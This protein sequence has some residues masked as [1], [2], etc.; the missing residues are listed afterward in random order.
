VEYIGNY[1][2]WINPEWISYLLTNPGLS[3]P[4]ETIVENDFEESQSSVIQRRYPNSCY[5]HKF[6][7]DVFPFELRLPI[8]VTPADWWFI[9]M[10]PGQLLPMHTDQSDEVGRRTNL[11]WMALSDYESGHILLVNDIVLTHYRKGD[12]YKFTDTNA[13]HGSCNLGINTRLIF[14]FTSEKTL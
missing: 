14:N 4:G 3:L 7:P 13:L 8:E 9:K 6:T 10:E 1:A 12:L 11:F 5:W 2:N